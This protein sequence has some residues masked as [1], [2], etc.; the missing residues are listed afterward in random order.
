VPLEKLP[1]T[2]SGKVD[3]RAL[4]APDAGS[5][6]S[7]LAYAAPR[8]AGERKL[9]ALWSQVLGREE[10]GVY[11]N[12]FHLGGH[13]LRAI[14]LVSLI[15]SSL[16]VEIGLK[17]VFSHPTIAGQAALLGTYESDES[18]QVQIPLIEPATDY[19]LSNAQRRL[20]VLSKLDE[21]LAAYNIPAAVR[22][23]GAL[24]VWSL[25][26]AFSLLFTRHESLRTN[27]IEKAGEG[28]QVIREITDY[29][30]AV[31][32]CLGTNEAAIQ[33]LIHDHATHLFDLANDLLLKLELLV[34]N[35]AEHLLLFNMHHIISDGWSI[36]VL[37]EELGALYSA[38]LSGAETPE[39]ILLPL[40]IQYKDYAAWQNSQLEEGSTLEDV[41]GYWQ[42]QLSGISP[43]ELPTDFARPQLK[44]YQGAQLSGLLPAAA[45]EKLEAFSTARGASLFMTLTS[46]INVLLHRYTGQEDIVIGSP[47]AGRRH[48]D[49]HGQIGFYINT[50]ALRTRLRGDMPF[51]ELL[52]QQKQT[53]LEAF[54]H[55]HYPF[56]RL[57][58]ELDLPRDMSRSVVFDVMVVL[59]NNET[60]ALQL[61]GLKIIPE[62]SPTE[63]AKYDLTFNFA[64]T[65]AGLA[66]DIEY[67]T[68]L[69]RED[70]IARLM[71]Q[72]TELA[73]SVLSSP[74]AVVGRLNI[75]PASERSLLLHTF[76]DTSGAC[77]SEDTIVSLFEQQA[78]KTPDAIALIIDD[79]EAGDRELTYGSLNALANSVA[80][81]LRARYDVKSD[82]IVGFQLE[83]TEWMVVGMLGILKSG[84]AYLPI[85]P[86]MP[87]DRIRY[88]LEDS[89]A[90]ILLTDKVQTD[91]TDL[92][93]VERI[94]SLSGGGV[95]NPAAQGEGA[96]LAYVMY[97]SGSTG[98]PKGTQIVHRGVIR[99]VKDTNYVR[100]SAGSTVA[101]IASV[102]FDASTFEIWGSLLN[103]GRLVILKGWNGNLGR[104]GEVLVAHKVNVALLITSPFNLMIEE[105]PESL[106][107][108]E[109]LLIGGEALSVSHINKALALL[110]ATELV[111]CYGPTE[112]TTIT[113]YYRIE[114]RYYE[115]SIPIGRP[116]SNTEVLVV[117]GDGML[118]PLGAVGEL[119]TGGA[120][121]ARGYLNNEKLT[122][123]K[124]IAH[125]YKPGERLYR[126]GD[127]VRWL[128][129]GQLE[130]LGRI[131][132]QL[133]I[134]GYRIEAGEIEYALL[135]HP[136]IQSAV[137]VDYAF[138]G[139]R[140]LVAYVVAASD[141]ALPDSSE[142]RIHLSKTLPDYM[143]PAYYVGLKELPLTSNGKVDRRALPAPAAESLVG[144]TEYTAPRNSTEQALAELWGQVLSRG[145]IGIH[146]NFFHLGGHSLRAIR[147]VSL[148]RESLGEE[149][150][151]KGVFSHPTIAGQ[152][153]L[154]KASA[155]QESVQAQIPLIEPAADYALSNAQRRLWVLSKLDEGLA[156][157]NMPAAIRL[158]GAL[159]VSSLE[160]AFSL[161]FARHE[162]LRTN[163]I[164]K[165][166][167]GRQMV[168]AVVD[169]KLAVRDCSGMNEEAIQALVH[170]HATHLFSLA[171]DLLLKLELLQLGEE[172][173][174][175]LFN[176]HHIISDG[177]S[178]NVLLEELGTLYS[179]CLSGAETPENSLQPLR[180]QYK[181]YAA[182][183]NNQLAEGSALAKG[184]ALEEV[185]GYWQQQ[186]A[187]I[188][189]LEL[190]T[191]F[192]RAQVK[193]YQGAQLSGLLP[194]AA[195][196]KLEAFST[197]QGA[198]L[199]M[200]LTSLVNVLLYRY[201]GQEDIVIGSPTAGR[202]H[203]DLHGQIGFYINTLVLRTR[204]HGDMTFEELLAQQ[205]QTILEA[206]EHEH[207]PFDRLVEELDLP[208]DMSRSAVFDVMVV[209]Q[210]NEEI[211]L[212]LSGLQVTPEPS[213]TGLAKYDLTFAFAQT[214][215]GLAIGV[216]YN[217]NLFRE[218]RIVGILN[219]FSELVSSSLSDQSMIIGRLNILP[220]AERALLQHTFNDA[221]ASY[222][223]EATLVSLFEAQIVATPMHV[224]VGY[225]GTTL[226]YE[227]LNECSNRIAHYLRHS[228]GIQ[229]DDVVALQLERTDWLV[230]AILGVLKSGAAYLPIGPDLPEARVAYMLADSKAK[231]LLTDG[232]THPRA[233]AALLPELVLGCVENI[234]ADGQW[235]SANPVNINRSEDLAYILYTS[236]ST[237]QPK[238]VMITHE[239]VVRLMVNDRHLFDFSSSDVWTLFHYYGF[240]FSVW[241][242]WGAL[243]YGGKVVIVSK[244]VALDPD[245]FVGLLISE[246]VTVLNQVPSTFEGVQQAL[247]MRDAE[248][249]LRYIIFGGSALWPAKLSA[250]HD[251]YPNIRL[252]NMYGITETTVH[253]TIKEIGDEE[254]RSGISNIGVAIPT[255]SCYVLDSYRQLLPPGIAGE[256]CVSGAGLARGYLNNPALTAEKFI[257]HPF[258]TGERL[259]KSGD[260]AR[261]LPSGELEYLGRMDQQLKIRGYRIEAGEIEH[262]LLTHPAISSAAVIG[263]AFSEGNELVAYVVASTDESLPE[264]SALRRHLSATLPDYMVPAYF[265]VLDKI[266]LTVNGKV[267]R[268]LLPAPVAVNLGSGA[269]H[270]APRNA[271]ERR[272][273]ELWAQVLARDELGIHD[274]FFHLGGHSLRAI[275]LVSLIRESLGVEIGLK[276][277]FSHPTIAGQA[278]LLD[279]AIFAGNVQIPLIELAADYALSNA[280]RRLWVLS[281]LDEVLA[282]YNMPAAIRL[283]GE[284]DVFSLEKALS[285]LFVRHE[286]LRTNFI[287]RAGE[288]RQIVRA[289]ADYKLAVRDCRGASE[290]AIQYLIHDHATHLFDL[291][292]DLLLKLELLQVG[293]EEH[294]FLLNMHHI[295]SD[296]WSINVLLEEL[297]SLYNA[298]LSGAETPEKILPP[299]RIQYKDYAVWQ[300][301]QLAEGSTLEA[302]RSYWREQLSGISPLEL[303]T[304]FARPQVKT[305][306]GSQLSGLL[307]AAAAEKLEAFSTERGASLFMT[308]TSLVNVLLYRYT[309]QED[310]VIGSPTAGRRHAD[311]HGQIGFYINTLALRTRLRG[312][313]AFSELL[314]QQ[315]QTIL[316]A[317]EHEHYPF[318]WLVEEL[319]LPRDMSRS[320]VFDVMVVL[321]NNE[322]TTLELEGLQV[323][324]EP[325]ATGLAK[326]DLTFTFGEVRDGLLVNINYNTNLFREDRIRRMLDHLTELVTSALAR[327]EAPIGLLTMLPA[328]EHRLLLH[329]FNDT[330]VPRPRA[331]TIVSLFEQQVMQ[332]PYR[333]AVVVEEGD[334]GCRELTYSE[335]NA[336]ANR[337]AHYLRGEYKIKPEDIIALQL[338]RSEWM[339]IAILGVLKS[340]AAY[341][342]VTP[343]TPVARTQY[344]LEGSGAK[345]LLT[346]KETS[347]FL[348]V[349]PVVNIQRAI[350]PNNQNPGIVITD[351]SLAYVIYTSGSTG[352]PKGVMIEHLSVVN[353]LYGFME[354]CY[355]ELPPRACNFAMV[356]SYAFDASVKTLF[357]S[358][359]FG[360][361]LLVVPDEIKRDGYAFGE[362]LRRRHIEVMDS[363]PSLMRILLGA[364]LG[365]TPGLSLLVI[366]IGGEALSSDMIREFYIRP[367]AGGVSIFNVYG[368]TEGTVNASYHRVKAG[369]LKEGGTIPI[370]RPLGNYELL[371]LSTGN[372]L[373]GLGIA[374][375]LCIGGT[376]LARGYLNNSVLTAE[377]FIPHPYKPG[378]RMYRTGDLVRWLPDGN[379]EYL[380]RIDHQLKIRGYRI[381]AGEVEH[382]LLTHPSIQSAVVTD[383]AFE[384]GKELVASVVAAAD[385]PLPD[386]S[387]LR[388]HLS[389]T[390]PDYM[391]PAY[392]VV[393]E[394]LP[395]TSSGKV[396]R[397]ALPAPSTRLSSS[398]GRHIPPTS[399][400][401]QVLAAIW[402]TV[403]G[404]GDAQ[405]IDIRDNF[406]HLG[407]H[408]LKA[409]RLQ[410]M[411]AAR[412]QVQLP[413][414][415]IF[416]YATLFEMALQLQQ[417]TSAPLSLGSLAGEGSKAVI[418]AF[419]PLGGLSVFYRRWSNLLEG[420]AVYAFDYADEEDLLEKY[421]QEMLSVQPEG[422]YLL[423]GYSLGGNLAYELALYLESRGVVVNDLLLLDSAVRREVSSAMTEEEIVQGRIDE[424]M[425]DPGLDDDMRAMLG[426]RQ[427]YDRMLS[428]CRYVSTRPTKG[429]LQANIHL[430]MSGDDRS[431]DDG[432]KQW[433]NHT[434]GKYI[435]Y[436]GVG[437]HI[438]M[439]RRPW[440]DDNAA[441]LLQL[442]DGITT[443][444]ISVESSPPPE[445]R[446]LQ[447]W[448]EYRALSAE[449]LLLQQHE[450]LR[451]QE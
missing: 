281:K 358:L 43:L 218:E 228:C 390:L 37:L 174:L 215:E 319:D 201:T 351:S 335:L 142:L 82:D 81:H 180:I 12:F 385:Q 89:G 296:G 214:S 36:N 105:H 403:L 83:R 38:C 189:P 316:E 211:K 157:Y 375:E 298:C 308:L 232:Q 350:H 72:F 433:G 112:N 8:T 202:R 434:R 65:P 145:E 368:P 333:L 169:Y 151:L 73:D 273:A 318:D 437:E 361:R 60:T 91:F 54:E 327:P 209:L 247:L 317:F 3:R 66:I 77:P 10:I 233:Q 286:S 178:I 270:V 428:F 297:G 258:K 279:T 321:Q 423:M 253:V 251:R 16:G 418:F 252:M 64:Q 415:V 6:G 203:A 357:G 101:Q 248:L 119:V 160:K 250:F 405:S 294:L 387:E 393:L 56:D 240:D 177:W 116:I 48:A 378:E 13:S 159:D 334:T 84:A 362:L 200:T 11:D 272:L 212:E 30:L 106:Q 164:E 291:A 322:E 412:L 451:E 171:N 185:R 132:H 374:G 190:P 267:D 337:L 339:V 97:T 46:L 80:H 379:I 18:V 409:I 161:L 353:L 205:K 427:H 346:D 99:L 325:S 408:S 231:A 416:R 183:Q 450:E 402:S 110:P 401:E 280:Q 179:A 131:D 170:E 26:K 255:L 206:F 39:N 61:E 369:E 336:A 234:A 380:G 376:G 411:I 431:D 305:Y 33:S 363:T 345:V 130:Y 58:E 40:R 74:S 122:A 47:T 229:P 35:A 341:L 254:I 245:L 324:P 349:L 9:A 303:P 404:I 302:V 276:E 230:V 226:R 441:T 391:L 153:E 154:L 290:A 432:W 100:L 147:L 68:D 329:T 104:L 163:F 367:Y 123:E 195:A 19:A 152:A 156:A 283:Q 359:L 86:D 173:H 32:D 288:G 268:R 352:Q 148:I 242:M 17:D 186:L 445:E 176:M 219:H 406:F 124:F 332:T 238:G 197:A 394:K 134:R 7:R 210:N 282:A 275:R 95:N 266:P 181:D 126:T 15:R 397:R 98:R 149:I 377:K 207:Y 260:L 264:S 237:G 31:R 23:Q 299:L 278:G 413:L 199:F 108:L 347:S 57:V 208:R 422:P 59:Q 167:E 21:G 274:N 443:P 2:S 344:M 22:L 338:E 259:Y 384:H 184:N 155:S 24:D 285:L 93:A 277:V 41:R 364:G 407:G 125:P 216:E 88:M 150:G 138:E 419:P 287:E 85:A 396:D 118:L 28:R 141:E 146:D 198:S 129:E 372:V 314:T 225:A 217:T 370:G 426:Q 444:A 438:E 236:G 63:Y 128:P 381:E 220:P 158:Q 284:L 414:T 1:L 328:E 365:S 417:I 55:E 342:P 114:R 382:A 166:G 25:E 187:D 235:S 70:S 107:G 191:D 366:P 45:T 449:L 227:E 27:F 400:V 144:G 115:R 168:R 94:E 14:R 117:D 165:A 348:E 307:P 241:E 383:Y 143:L 120:G 223:A 78:A 424:A 135:S 42:Q 244:E 399:A 222:P 263:Y 96:S 269:A 312:E 271:R 300:N 51:D 224:A 446:L 109:Q 326:F 62:P 193:T 137:V 182:W 162:S 371:V 360:H 204:L 44:T 87:S 262:A 398:S 196:K 315:K 175:L 292:N 103:G 313:M 295:I 386:S 301:S 442:L 140:E 447:L 440:L 395:L 439:F 289:I 323:R 256:L 127:L 410:S 90:K 309:G 92:V 355:A 50:L 75:L 53:I 331:Q 246:G 34:L 243:L 76:N 194:L 121:L 436:Q 188:T 213:A 102:S 392:Y 172:E 425:A 239:N 373:S 139:G 192:V 435:E 354:T 136:L 113:T 343:D 49:L 133:K 430:L 448:Q 257:A 310:I 5:L 388:S 67:N 306:Q 249:C 389:A 420:Y 111:N 20:W 340:G 79:T 320:A 71:S 69:Y 304:D 311:L 4:P 221:T 356:A 330:A 293:A 52:A 429:R 29:K 265:V 421:Y 261:W